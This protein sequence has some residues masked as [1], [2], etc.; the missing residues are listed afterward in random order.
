MN[1]AQITGGKWWLPGTEQYRVKLAVRSES[2]ITDI[3]IYDGPVLLRRFRP[4][5]PPLAGGDSGGASFTFDLP[6]DQQ[7]NLVAEITDANGKRAITGG[8]FIRSWLNWRF[9]CGDRGNSICDAIQVDEAGAYMT[10]PTAPYQRKM[11]AFG[12][13]AGYGER[14]FNILPPDFD[15]GMRPVGMHVQPWFQIPDYTCAP[16]SSTLES[17]MEV[18]LCSRD[19]LMQ[20]NTIVGY[21]PGKSDYHA[22][23]PKVAPKDI[24]GVRVRYR[25]LDIT[26]RAHDPGVLL[27]EGSLHFDRAMKLNHLSLFNV[28]HTSEQGE[29]DH[30]ALVTPETTVSGMVAGEPF[31]AGGRMGPGS[32]A[33]VF[34]SL[35]GSTGIIALDDG[36]RA[37]VYSQ[38]PSNHIGVSLVDVP[39]EIKAGEELRYRY[40]LM[41]GRAG[42]GPNTS[43]W[44]QFAVRMGL[45]GKPAYEVKDVKLGNV[46]GTK[47]LLELEPAEGGF[48]GAVTHADLPIRL[49]VRVSSMNPNWTFAWFDLDRKEWYPSAID[50]ETRT[51]F[52]T[53]DTRRGAHR[54]FAGHPVLADN[55]DVHI[56]VLSDGKSEIRAD[57]NNVT[58]KPM[59]LTIRLNPAL[60]TSAPQ[61][62]ELASGEM[63]TVKFAY[64]AN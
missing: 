49:P 29:G 1:D 19:G 54:L 20:D 23:G 61:Q 13:C 60:G 21:F 38:P 32:Y 50:R 42:E 10:G 11:T 6:H 12:V 62:M 55:P 58:D 44:E 18:P 3:R 37:E 25:Y 43:E 64:S 52:F 63:R 15:G 45:R 33:C 48:A 16:P 39:R 41:H 40:V 31:G 26:A 5:V 34:P 56:S 59:T 57:L 8:V 14:H 27:L 24:D 35:W 46:T 17:R 2:A 4:G 28:F 36:S 9:M 7:R 47:F 30:F 53:L 22:W 51:G